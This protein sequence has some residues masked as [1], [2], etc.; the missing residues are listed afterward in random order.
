MQNQQANVQQH[1]D[2]CQVPRFR[3]ITVQRW[4]IIDQAV[5]D[6]QHPAHHHGGAA[7]QR[8]NHIVEHQPATLQDDRPTALGIGHRLPV[9]QIDQCACVAGEQAGQQST[10]FQRGE[11]VTDGLVARQNRWLRFFRAC[12]FVA[13]MEV[14]NVRFV[15]SVIVVDRPCAIRQPGQHAGLQLTRLSNRIQQVLTTGVLMQGF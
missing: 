4:Q 11:P 14:D 10:F 1:I 7:Q 5:G 2:P 13:G 15:E 12:E 6:L 8:Q 9:S 3:V